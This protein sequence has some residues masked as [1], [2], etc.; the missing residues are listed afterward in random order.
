MYWSL[1]DLMTCRNWFERAGLMIEAEGSEP[2]N[3]NPG[4][5]VLIARSAAID[6]PAASRS[7]AR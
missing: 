6:E 7:S 1:A 2:R 4:Y 3:G 5:A